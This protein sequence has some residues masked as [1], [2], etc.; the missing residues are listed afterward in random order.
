MFLLIALCVTC[1]TTVA[2]SIIAYQLYIQ[3][4][5]LLVQMEDLRRHQDVL[6]KS[7]Q[8]VRGAA[9][10]L[11]VDVATHVDG[12]KTQAKQQQRLLHQDLETLNTATHT[13]STTAARLDEVADELNHL[14]VSSAVDLQTHASDLTQVKAEMLELNAQLK[15]TKMALIEKEQQLFDTVMQLQAALATTHQTT[16]GCT[17]VINDVSNHLADI[18]A[19]LLRNNP[20]NE[21]QV[22]IQ[23]LL[24]DFATML[25]TIAR[26]ESMVR[27]LTEM[28][29]VHQT[30]NRA[31]L[32]EIRVLGDENRQLQEAIIELTHALVHQQNTTGVQV[33]QASQHRLR[34]FHA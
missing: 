14:S 7:E 11:A 18:N 10:H 24:E 23:Q 2:A 1:G 5:T 26:L 22:D 21:P 31:Q 30:R 28:A 17:G 32:D 15:L 29:S 8:A 33:A 20:P 9:L 13:V 27:Q 19:H 12:L 3:N 4:Q 16:D 34:L 6:A 25:T